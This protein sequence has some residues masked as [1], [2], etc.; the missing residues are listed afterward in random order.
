MKSELA[1]RRIAFKN[2]MVRKIVYQSVLYPTYGLVRHLEFWR[3]SE[4]ST[5]VFCDTKEYRNPKITPSTIVRINR[6]MA[7]VNIFGEIPPHIEALMDMDARLVE[8][9][10]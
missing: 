9:T 8:V 10:T 3:F 5:T 4:E 2:S 1:S 7:G 6:L